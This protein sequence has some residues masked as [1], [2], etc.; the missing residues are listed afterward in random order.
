VID[1]QAKA[2]AN[3][4]YRQAHREEI[5]AKRRAVAAAKRE[6]KLQAEKSFRATGSWGIAIKEISKLEG[7][8]I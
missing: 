5:N 2:Q 1:P 3:R 8:K 6:A 4:K 7:E